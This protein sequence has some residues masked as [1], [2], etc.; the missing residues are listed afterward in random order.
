MK[1]ISTVIACTAMLIGLCPSLQSQ[2]LS[3]DQWESFIVENKT[4]LVSDTFRLQRFEN[5]ISDNWPY[6]M[7][8]N[9]S[10][11]N[12]SVSGISEAKGTRLMKM[13]L[14]G[15]LSFFEV[16]SSSHQSIKG[17]VAYAGKNLMKG[18]NLEV[19]LY[20]NEKTE[21]VVL[22]KI[23]SDNNNLKLT[24]TTINRTLYDID[25]NVAPSASN[26]KGGYYCIDSVYLL[27]GIPLYSLFKGKSSWNDT[28]AWSDL[29]AERHRHALVKGEV[30]VTAD[31]H[32]DLVDLSGKL[33][34]EQNKIFSLKDL[35]IH[36]TSSTIQNDGEL[37]SSGKMSLS[38]TFPE[39]GVWYFVSFPFDVY[40][41]GIDSSFS[42]KDDTPNGGGNFI[43]ALTYNGEL[44]NSGQT[45]SRN[46]EVL[47][48]ATIKGNIPVFEK[49]KGYL[50]AIDAQASN[51]SIRFTSRAGAIPSTFGKSGEIAINIPYVVDS[52]RHHAG[53]YLCG[54]PLPAPLHVSELKHP[55]LDGYV[56]VFNGE[57]YT[58]IPLDGNYMLPPYSAFFLKAKQSVTLIIG[59]T[60][61]NQ[62]SLVLSG[63]LPLRGGQSEPTAE[64]P[65]SNGS[66]LTNAH[67]QMGTTV[68]SI[69]N[70]PENGSVTIF[71]TIG[72]QVFST[73]YTAGESKQISLP[74]QQGFYIL[75]LQ[76]QNRRMEYKFIR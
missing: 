55:D 23:P 34:I 21:A 61:E 7:S 20:D 42:L 28:T 25:F 37:L 44:R 63:M 11:I 56:Y 51:T 5:S 53:W 14:G 72:R 50:L 18:E 68:F 31:V 26:T 71:D 24:H 6:T 62:E 32:C 67:Y 74:V 52:D 49:N 35:N 17:G 45:V 36:D 69:I 58:S 70:A 16:Y 30:T 54:N 40:A 57:N 27:G 48:E 10:I 13:D 3:P 33:K 64:I 29:P 1:K 38:R 4:I 19:V 73:K 15:N 47:P 60:D 43:Y 9:C 22:V 76:T 75:L 66:L 2:T 8:S 39:K 59:T 12:T 65:T 41:D 46:W